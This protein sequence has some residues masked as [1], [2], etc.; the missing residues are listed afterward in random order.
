MAARQLV[1]TLIFE[2]EGV[3]QIALWSVSD[4]TKIPPL[5]QIWLTTLPLVGEGAPTGVKH[6]LSS[7]ATAVWRDWAIVVLPVADSADLRVSVHTREKGSAELFHAEVFWQ[8]EE[9][10][11]TT[12]I[13]EWKGYIQFLDPV[14]DM[15]PQLH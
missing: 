9:M 2:E 7:I 11:Y 8:G 14:S 1:H 13:R 10:G 6:P 15:I 5:P 4:E 3:R 12:D